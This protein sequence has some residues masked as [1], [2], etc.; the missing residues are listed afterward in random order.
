MSAYDK[1]CV[2]VACPL[3]FKDLKKDSDECNQALA[4][5]DA[6]T[7]AYACQRGDTRACQA[8]SG[9]YSSQNY[10][11][12][13]LLKPEYSCRLGANPWTETVVCKSNV[14]HETIEF[15]V[16]YSE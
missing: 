10:C 12:S 8:E 14:F 1:L 3:V 2:S 15:A 13:L 9:R 16:I 7:R 11:H 5:C 4:T 6:C